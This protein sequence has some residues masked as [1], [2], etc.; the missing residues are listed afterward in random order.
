[1]PF[2]LVC[3]G[4][5]RTLS[6]PDAARGKSIRCPG[7]RAVVEAAEPDPVAAAEPA[8]APGPVGGPPSEAMS[9]GEPTRPCPRCGRAVPAEA[10]KCPLCREWIDRGSP[11]PPAFAPAPGGTR[12][13]GLAIASMVLG[14]IGVLTACMCFGLAPAIGALVTGFLALAEFKRDPSVE[15]RGMATAGVVMGFIAVAVS[16]MVIVSFMVGI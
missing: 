3:P 14:I 13:S 12:T 9:G 4:C 1:M 7:C 15:G 6:V 2:A 8:P 11:P 16:L 10:I 5:Q